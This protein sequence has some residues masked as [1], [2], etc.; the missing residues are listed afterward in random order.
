MLDP[1]RLTTN[2]FKDKNLSDS[3]LNS[4]TEYFLIA[5]AQ[6]LNNPGGIYNSLLVETTTL[7]QNYYGS[8]LTQA[9]K[10]AISK[11]VTITLNNAFDAVIAKMRRLRGLVLYK[12]KAKSAV[13][14]AFYP[15]GMK[16]YHHVKFSDA[17]LYFLR[18]RAIAT[19]H[20]QAEYPD[21]VAELAT[22]IEAYLNARHTRTDIDS[23]L[24]NTA[25]S[26]HL[27][28]KVLTLQLTKCFLTIAA[29]HL[30]N[31]EHFAVYYDPRFL[32]L[33]KGKKKEK[34]EIKVN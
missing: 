1:L 34:G 9:G 6:P 30:E 10:E 12:F 7:Y 24:D 21:D 16:Q 22:L 11:G 4:F 19:M 32:P 28:R 2:L 13:Y 20:L 17:E 14:K 31:P 25:T 23:V 33:R 18:F 26:R 8:L 5:L 27:N 3:S 15:R 29:N